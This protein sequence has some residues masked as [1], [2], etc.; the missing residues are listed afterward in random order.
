MKFGLALRR[1]TG[2]AEDCG[3]QDV[4]FHCVSRLFYCIAIA[5]P[6]ADKDGNSPGVLLAARQASRTD[7]RPAANKARR[8]CPAVIQATDLFLFQSIKTRMIS[9]LTDDPL[10]DKLPSQA[11]PR[12]R[13]DRNIIDVGPTETPEFIATEV[14]RDGCYLIVTARCLR[15]R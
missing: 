8:R 11:A 4:R 14:A 3:Q 9:A 13:D 7:R 12:R 5:L 2:Q 10:G 15:A 6:P 1:A